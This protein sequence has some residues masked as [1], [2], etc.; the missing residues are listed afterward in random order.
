MSIVITGNPGVGKHTI[1][2]ELA[3][4]LQLKI[5][6]INQIAKNSGLF[7]KN[8]E[9]NDVDTEKLKE[10]LKQ[11][12]SSDCIIVGHLAPYVLDKEQVKTAI[13][14]RRSPYDLIQVYKQR[15]YSDKKSKE[16][17]GSEILG[18]ITHNSINQFNEKTFQINVTGKEIQDVVNKI[19]SIILGNLQGEDVDWLELVTNRN[20]LKKFF[21]D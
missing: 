10:I 2:K 18:V 21:V 13:V 6:D 16:N 7:E 1:S 14:L 17:T 4:K 11:E 12:I 8:N 20:D 5:I 9:S 3:K 15:E 19:E